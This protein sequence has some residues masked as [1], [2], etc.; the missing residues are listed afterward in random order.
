MVA[1]ADISRTG[2]LGF[3]EF[4]DLW[5]N[6]LKWKVINRKNSS[7]PFVKNA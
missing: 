1:T 5:L 2:K 3:D 6:F 4:T 7:L